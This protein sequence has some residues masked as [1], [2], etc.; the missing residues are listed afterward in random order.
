MRITG[1]NLEAVDPIEAKLLDDFS[2]VKILMVEANIIKIHIKVNTKVTI[3]KAITTK[4][5]MVNTTTH[6]E[7]IIRVII[8][9]NL[10]EEAMV[11]VELIAM[12]AVV[13][14]LIIEV[15]TTTDTISIMVTIMTTSLSNMTHHVHYVVATITPPNFFKGEHDINNIM[16]KMNISGHQSQQSSLYS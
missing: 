8:M 5:F 3:I 12:D 9:A 7:A 13:V 6:V 14:G 4:V 16:E 1:V 15:I 10:E 2:E 11:M